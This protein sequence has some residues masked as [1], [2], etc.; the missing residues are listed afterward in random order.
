[1]TDDE[2]LVKVKTALGIGG[3]YQDET[4]KLYIAEVKEFLIDAGISETIVSS[5][6]AIGIICRG[7]SDLW[8][9]GVNEAKFSD[10]FIMRA[11]QLAL[12]NSNQDIPSAEPEYFKEEII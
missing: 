8:N 1:M 3:T 11:T 7:V 6:K 5:T 10:Y 9:Y 2:L 4:L 12:S